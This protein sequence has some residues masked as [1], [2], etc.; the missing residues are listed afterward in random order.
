MRGG[1]AEALNQGIMWGR[2]TLA[3]GNDYVNASFNPN[4]PNREMSIGDLS[5]CPSSESITAQ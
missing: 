1:G 4:C 2:G 5:T 3:W